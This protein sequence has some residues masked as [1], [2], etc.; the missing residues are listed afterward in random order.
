MQGIPENIQGIMTKSFGSNIY[1]RDFEKTGFKDRIML[2]EYTQ[3]VAH[4]GFGRT[5]MGGFYR[6]W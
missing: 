4:T 1:P 6:R 3:R 5:A 2:D